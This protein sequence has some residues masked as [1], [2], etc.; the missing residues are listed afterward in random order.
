M[1]LIKWLD[2]YSINIEDMDEQHKKWVGFINWLYE[3]KQA[4]WKITT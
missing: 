1:P 3:A 2:K 4:K